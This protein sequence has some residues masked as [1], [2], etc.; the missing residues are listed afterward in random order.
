MHDNNDEHHTATINKK[1]TSSI[2]ELWGVDDSAKCRTFAR[3][4]YTDRTK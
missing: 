3:L 4:P 2:G 1:K